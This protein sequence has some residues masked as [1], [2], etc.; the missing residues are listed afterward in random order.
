MLTLTEVRFWYYHQTPEK[1]N[2]IHAGFEN[3]NETELQ[4]KA[5]FEQI[6]ELYRDEIIQWFE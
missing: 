6:R 3:F 4:G 2:E 5:I 1:K